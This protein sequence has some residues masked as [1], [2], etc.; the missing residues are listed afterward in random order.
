MDDIVCFEEGT[1]DGW[2]LPIAM[3]PADLDACT[4]LGLQGLVLLKRVGDEYCIRGADRIGTIL[5]PSG[6]S[7]IIKS[8][9]PNVTIL[10]WLA[11]LR[12]FPDLQA[13]IRDYGIS[14]EGEFF[15]Y[16]ARLFVCELDKVTRIHL[17]RDY[18][19]IIAD[20]SFVR[21]RILASRFYK[22][23]HRLPRIPQSYRERTLNTKPNIVL[24]RA[25]DKVALLLRDAPSDQANLYHQLKD[26]WSSV[27]RE[28]QDIR[29]TVV[30]VQMSPPPGYRFA[31]QLARLILTG[32]SIDPTSLM[33]GQI[34]TLSMA[35]VWERSVRKL[36]GEVGCSA[37]WELAPDGERIRR[38]D[39]PTGA[40]DQLRWMKPDVL[41]RQPDQKWVVDAKYKRAFAD[42]SRND[43]FQ[44]CGY[45]LGFS[46][47]RASLVYPTDAE[48]S[49]RVLLDTC[50]GSKKA[51]LDSIGLPMGGGPDACRHSLKKIFCAVT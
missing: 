33:G 21:G 15:K 49:C 24:A 26:A 13:W 17:R 1:D 45:I 3:S 32:A 22:T 11:Y 29:S 4:R 6:R 14:S 12:E 43:R 19:E 34:F 51:T 47:G 20:N 23:F 36:C 5:L 40:S 48:S 37:G 46:S 2:G 16:L 7:L 30:Q 35:S 31:L 9:I 44:L 41:L 50:F 27:G 8:K 18:T 10:E 38:W 42:E 25:L 28:V 39:D